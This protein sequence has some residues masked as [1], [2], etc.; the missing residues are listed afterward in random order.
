MAFSVLWLI[1]CSV[2][3]PGVLTRGNHEFLP[4]PNGKTIGTSLDSQIFSSVVPPPPPQSVLPS[5]LL[6]TPPFLPSDSSHTPRMPLTTHRHC[7]PHPRCPFFQSPS[8][9]APPP[10][11]GEFSPFLT[12]PVRSTNFS[13]QDTSVTTVSPLSPPLSRFFFF[14]SLQRY[15]ISAPPLFRQDCLPF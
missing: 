1:P 8:F 11:Y 9:S 15:P 7:V 12:H 2:C 13:F 3:I 10:P 6:E 4:F 5:D 14:F